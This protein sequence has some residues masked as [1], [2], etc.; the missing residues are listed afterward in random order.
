M[1]PTPVFPKIDPTLIKEKEKSND[2]NEVVTVVTS[3][4]VVGS[5]SGSLIPDLDNIEIVPLRVL[6]EEKAKEIRT[7]KAE[8][9]DKSVVKASV[10]RLLALKER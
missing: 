5:D 3:S 2:K 7:L 9:A 6:I 8:K 4:A 1:T 10:E